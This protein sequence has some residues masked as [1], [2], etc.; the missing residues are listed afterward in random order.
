M[1]TATPAT[2]IPTV[3]IHEFSDCRNNSSAITATDF[4]QMKSAYEKIV[5]TG[6]PIPPHIAKIAKSLGIA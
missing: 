1:M 2:T 6:T 3:R 5:A 4:M